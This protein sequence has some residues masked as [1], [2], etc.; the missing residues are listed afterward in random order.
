MSKRFCRLARLRTSHSNHDFCGCAPIVLSSG[1]K[2][3]GE[4]LRSDADVVSHFAVPAADK[5]GPGS[6]ILF[7]PRPR[8]PV[9]LHRAACERP[10]CFRGRRVRR[11]AS[12]RPQFR[13]LLPPPQSASSTRCCS[14]LPKALQLLG[15]QLAEGLLVLPVH[16]TFKSVHP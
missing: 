6:F 5:S 8:A 4:D 16:R 12:V 13:S 9:E 2:P 1:A 7:R 3:G 15:W 10:S 14:R 11:S